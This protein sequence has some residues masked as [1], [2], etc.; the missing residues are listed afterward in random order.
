MGSVLGLALPLLFFCWEAGVTASS[1]ETTTLAVR[2]PSNFMVVH[3]IPTDTSDTSA[4]SSSPRTGTSSVKPSTERDPIEAIFD[5]L[6]TNDSSE[7][8]RKIASD[9]LTLAHTSTEAEHLHPESR[10][11]SDS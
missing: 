11:S 5:T 2:I 10:S 9:L 3:P 7:E 4:T 1:E 6:C 8:A